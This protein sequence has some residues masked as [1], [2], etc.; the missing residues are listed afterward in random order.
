MSAMA[1][2]I[3]GVCLDCL[4]NRLFRQI[5]ENLNVPRHSPFDDV[6]MIL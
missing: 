4:R 6:I 3:T 1:S 5:K 2:Q